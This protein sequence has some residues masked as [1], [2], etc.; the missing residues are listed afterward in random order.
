MK[1]L[2]NNENIITPSCGCNDD[3]CV[4]VFVKSCQKNDSIFPGMELEEARDTQ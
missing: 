3:C 1:V 4:H 2:R